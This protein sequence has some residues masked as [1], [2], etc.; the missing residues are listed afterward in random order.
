MALHFQVKV[1]R[2]HRLLTLAGS[3][4]VCMMS[5]TWR[6]QKLK[7]QFANFYVVITLPTR[8]QNDA[9]IYSYIKYGMQPGRPTFV[10]VRDLE[11]GF[12]KIMK[13]AHARGACKRQ[14]ALAKIKAE[15]EKSVQAMEIYVQVVTSIPGVDSHDAN[16][17]NQTIGSIEA[18]AKSSKEYILE[19]TD[20][21]PTTA[22]TIT[23]FF[24]DPKFYLAPKIG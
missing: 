4:G 24:R 11:M 14:D 13:I 17:L 12:E 8:E 6:F 5:S 3:S 19:T 20:L 9:L 18:I 15:K 21:S 22:E 2:Y 10:P 16:V 1:H 23:S 7:E